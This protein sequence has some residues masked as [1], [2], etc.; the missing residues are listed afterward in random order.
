LKTE[1]TEIDG[2]L[3][4]LFT[5]VETDMMTPDDA[6][7]GERVAQI[8]QQRQENE[9]RTAMLERELNAQADQP[10]PER[11][12]AFGTILREQQ[13]NGSIEFPKAYLNLFIDRIEV[14]DSEVRIRGPLPALAGAASAKL[15]KPSSAVPSYVREWRA[16]RD[17]NS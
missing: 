10:T 1:G 3:R 6:V 9:D 2:R 8:K 4:K 5:L 7:L 11:I 14:D 15:P 17:S 12:P 16:R 13:K